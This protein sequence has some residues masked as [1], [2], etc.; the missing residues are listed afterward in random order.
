MLRFFLLPQQKLNVWTHSNAGCLRPHTKHLRMV[1]Q[2]ANVVKSRHLLTSTLAGISMD[3]VSNSKTSVHIGCFTRDYE[4]MMM[5]DPLMNA[6]YKATGTSSAI[7]ANRLSWFYNL[8]GPS[9]SLD[10]ACSSSL[11]AL[12]LACQSLLCGDSTMVCDPEIKRKY[13]SLDSTTL[14]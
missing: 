8:K 10:T 6:P 1:Y 13:I 14:T 3:S 7:L 12:H 9:L 11:T 5:S 4:Q 2:A